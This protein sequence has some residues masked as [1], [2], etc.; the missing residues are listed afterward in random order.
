M[1]RHLAIKIRCFFVV[2]LR[3]NQLLRAFHVLNQ[4]I[5]ICNMF[6]TDLIRGSLEVQK[7]IEHNL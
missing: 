6:D 4:R 2:K 5:L 3:N 7:T 1:N